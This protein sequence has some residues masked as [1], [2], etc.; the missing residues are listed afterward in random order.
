M[1]PRS[2]PLHAAQGISGSRQVN[3]GAFADVALRLQDPLASTNL[4]VGQVVLHSRALLGSGFSVFGE[5]SL[6]SVPAFQ[7]RVERLLF[8]WEASDALKVSAGRMH[9]PVT[10]WNST[11]HHGLWLQTTAS[12]PRM[13]GFDDAFIPNHHKGVQLSGLA[14][15]L[16]RAGVRYRFGVANSSDDDAPGDG[17]TVPF[18]GS[19]FGVL[20]VEPAATPF[21]RVGVSGNQDLEQAL[22]G[23]SRGARRTQAGAHVAYTRERPEIV[24]EVVVVSHTD[25][26]GESIGA[27]GRTAAAKHTD[28]GGAA[29]PASREHSQHSGA[30][31]TQHLSGSAYLQVAWRLRIAQERFKPYAR[32]EQVRLHAADGSLRGLQSQ[33]LALAGVRT[34]LTS[35]VALKGEGTW[36]VLQRDRWSAQAQL[37]AAW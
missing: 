32:Y 8:E 13:V 33:E 31:G 34:D 6:N 14:P 2:Q 37:S 36:D 19:V 21:L 10:W 28:H 7:A 18:S 22:A 12:R 23:Q 9:S 24:A 25:A 11:F 26:V 30:H 1:P 15:F 35:R 16:K 29:S 5:L 17:V 4:S 3:L 27:T 20:A